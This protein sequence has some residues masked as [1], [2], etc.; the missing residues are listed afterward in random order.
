MAN[1]SS[2]KT[3]VEALRSHSFL[4]R[5]ATPQS[6]IEKTI[7]I[8]L[9]GVLTGPLRQKAETPLNTVTAI[10]SD[11]KNDRA[12]DMVSDLMK[13]IRAIVLTPSATINEKRA[14]EPEVE[15]LNS[16]TYRPS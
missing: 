12:K 2:N 4:A 5:P 11:E 9:Q 8:D 10:K 6:S 3:V 1:E 13:A 15:E 14:V 16:S 7:E